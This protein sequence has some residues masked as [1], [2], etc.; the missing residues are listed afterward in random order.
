MSAQIIAFR[1]KD[2]SLRWFC[3]RNATEAR[4]RASLLSARSGVADWGAVV[5]AR[6]GDEAATAPP[7][8]ILWDSGWHPTEYVT[9]VRRIFPILF[10]D[11]EPA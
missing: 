2:E 7:E 3:H 8:P 11:N 5:A 10:D 1:S 9:G 6:T 4:R